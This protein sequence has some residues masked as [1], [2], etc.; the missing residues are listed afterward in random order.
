VQHAW[1]F[2]SR[3]ADSVVDIG[4]A[5]ERKLAARLLR[6][7]QT[8]EAEALRRAWRERAARAGAAAGLALGEAF[9]ILR[10]A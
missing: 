8:A 1:L 7:S 5:F 10:L 3:T 2:A 6:T 4:D 9:T